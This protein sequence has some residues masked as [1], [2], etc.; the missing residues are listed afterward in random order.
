MPDRNHT[1][2]VG[3]N[4]KIVDADTASRDPSGEGL[5]ETIALRKGKLRRLPA[6]LARLRAGCAVLGLSLNYDDAGL[7]SLLARVADANQVVDAV[8]RVTVTRATGTKP[9]LLVTASPVPPYPEPA[10]VIVATGTRRNEHSPFS[11][12]KT[13][14]C[15]ENDLAR[16]EAMAAGADDA[17][18]LN[19]QGRLADS[20]VANI[21]LLV[22]GGLITP[23]VEEGAM[24]G[25]ARAEVIRLAK[26]EE[27]PVTQ[28]L[29]ARASEIFLS[30]ALG[31]RPVVQ[32]GDAAVGDGEPGLITQLLATRI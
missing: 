22:D 25:V 13:L 32:I 4:G 15:P 24:P 5:F 31:I 14:D 8:L 20:T 16:T 7:E 18:L 6:H 28:D 3:L 23:P 12:I 26:A 11:R 10:R 30:N 2:K 21:F 1:M 9:T 29:L 17:L 19:T 27:R